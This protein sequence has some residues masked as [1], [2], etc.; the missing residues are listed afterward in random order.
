[1]M[2]LPPEIVLLLTF[3]VSFLVTYLSIPSIIS[4]AREKKLFDEPSRRKSH[5]QQVPTLGGVAI[6]A[7]ITI[8]GGSFINYSLLPSLQYIL[9]ACIIMFFIGI[10]DDILVIAPMKKLMGQIAA[11]L[12]L[13]IPGGLNFS[14]VQG[15]FGMHYISTVPSL[16]LT[17]FA[18]IVIVNSFNLIDG[19]DG[20]AASIGMLTTGFFGAWFFISGN[21]EYSLI[22]AT[23]FGA[24]LAFFRF[25]VFGGKNKIF[26]GDTGSLILGLLMSVQVILFNEKNIG[27]TS[28]FSIK[29]APAV[30]FAVLIIP[31]Y[32]TMRV[33]L[34]RM[35]RGR[36]PFSADKNHLHHCLLKLGFSHGR[37]TLIIVIANFCFIILALLLQNMGIVWMMVIILSIATVLS[38]Y[39]EYHVRK[40]NPNPVPDTAK[41]KRK[42]HHKEEKAVE[43]KSRLIL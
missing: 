40:T 13:I 5:V 41:Q 18:I 32:D 34:I 9:V 21:I 39:L 29:A 2:N 11:A 25:N 12:I 33:F 23:V 43:R 35:S 24:L 36:S 6:F 20:L 31:L 22:S 4:V 3:I 38:F 16:L 17:L 19:I 27:F 28:A 14:S 15:F 10:K 1:M 7:G 37:S 30:S 8:A 26:M 42:N